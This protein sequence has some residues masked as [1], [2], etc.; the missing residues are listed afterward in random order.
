MWFPETKNSSQ[1]KTKLSIATTFRASFP[2]ELQ[3]AKKD[4]RDN[5]TNIGVE[6]DEDDPNI[7]ING[8]SSAR[9]KTPTAMERVIQRSN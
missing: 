9:C 8:G 5:S 2:S 6:K 4:I 7:L 1:S 3:I